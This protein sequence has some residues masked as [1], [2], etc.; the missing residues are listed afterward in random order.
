MTAPYV[1]SP[2][3]LSGRIIPAQASAVEGSYIFCIGEDSA[4][5]QEYKLRIGDTLAVEQQVDT[6]AWDFYTF[7][8]KLKK[9]ASMPAPKTLISAAA[10]EFKTGSLV[11]TGDGLSGLLLPETPTNLL[12]VADPDK[13]IEISGTSNNNGT[14]R[15]SAVPWSQGKVQAAPTV[16]QYLNGRVAVIENANLANESPV[17]ATIKVLG[18]RWVASCYFAGVLRCQMEGTPNNNYQRNT[19]SVHCSKSYERAALRFELRLEAYS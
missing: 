2:G 4:N 1:R 13:L 7:A 16:S 19:M 9:P 3:E 6:A 8:W 5:P 17:S 14:F 15:I 18:L 12:T 11:N 10:C